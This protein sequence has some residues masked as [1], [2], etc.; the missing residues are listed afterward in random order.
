MNTIEINSREERDEREDDET[1]VGI[2]REIRVVKP[3]AQGIRAGTG[4]RS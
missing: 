4:G 1:K 3:L 2:G